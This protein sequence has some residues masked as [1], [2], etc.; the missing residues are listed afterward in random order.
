VNL[1][2]ITSG[3]TN[4]N[5]ILT[6]TAVS[7]NTGLIPNPTVNYSSASTTGSLTFTPV[8]NATGMATITVKVNDGGTSNSNV[9]QSFTVTVNATNQ[10]PTLDPIPDIIVNV[11]ASSQNI[12]L[13][14]ISD[15]TTNKSR[16]LRV[17]AA[18][19]NHQLASRPLI[20]YINPKT[21]GSLTFR[22]GRTTGTATI[23]VTVNNGAR[24]NN[25]ITR[26]F[27]VTIVPRNAS[28]SL[29]ASTAVTTRV[30]NNTGVPG[31][32]NPSQMA[33]TLAPVAHVRGQFA[34]TVAGA[35]G[36]RYVVEAS[37][38]LMHWVPVQT[39]T[40]PFRFVDTNASQFVQRFYR[41]VYAP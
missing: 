26:T 19:G 9:T 14:G 32:M 12:I 17:T 6:V 13:T 30:A 37:T 7:S 33:A 22:P 38:D 2:G 39:N 18:S 34:L 31:M 25:I 23:S 5:Q 40:A 3:A 24:K 41:S 27:K 36:H 15:G 29:V 10:P 28:T 8:T 1:S 20:R 21:N 35:T 16:R 4:E 11:G